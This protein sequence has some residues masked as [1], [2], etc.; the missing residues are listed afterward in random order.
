MAMRE[1]LALE[2]RNV[3][4]K[5]DGLKIISGFGA[6]C[7]RGTITAIIGAN[8]SGK[9]TLLGAIG[10]VLP[11][12]KGSIFLN[13]QNIS[14]L[15]IQE[16]ALARSVVLQNQRYTLGFT[17]AQI[18]RLGNTKITDAEVE[19]VLISLGALNLKDRI[20]LS[21][22]GGERQRVSIAHALIQNRDLILLD[23]P[24]AAQDLTSREK[25]Q[26]ILEDLKSAG[27]TVVF[28]AHMGQSELHWCDQ[29][30]DADAKQR[31]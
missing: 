21:L 26:Q 14:E 2:L 6:T 8:G 1:E 3:E 30:V 31:P 9:S 5:R 10:G 22:S 29:V 23:E 28:V 4:I 24:F 7:D 19:R 15:S 27:K 16:Q 25:I 20:V 18:M 12:S 17:V 13:G 11:I